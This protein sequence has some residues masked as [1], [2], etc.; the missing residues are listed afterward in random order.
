MLRKVTLDFL[1]ADSMLSAHADAQAEF[2]RR[3]I[4]MVCA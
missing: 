2:K 1:I 3:I 4:R